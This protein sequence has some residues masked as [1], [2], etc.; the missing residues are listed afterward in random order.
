MGCGQVRGRQS[1]GNE[2]D[3]EWAGAYGCDYN[4]Y[5]GGFLDDGARHLEYHDPLAM[6]AL[7]CRRC[8]DIPTVAGPLGSEK[9]HVQQLPVLDSR[10]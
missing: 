6:L 7:Q 10:R 8:K 4:G 3:I 1:A 2:V 9:D 5:L